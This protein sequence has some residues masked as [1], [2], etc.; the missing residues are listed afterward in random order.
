MDLFVYKRNTFED[1]LGKKRFPVSFDNP[2]YETNDCRTNHYD[3][4]TVRIMKPK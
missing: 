4:F 3:E 2:Y 1:E